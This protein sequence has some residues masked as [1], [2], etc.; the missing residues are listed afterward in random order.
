MIFKPALS[1]LRFHSVSRSHLPCSPI[2]SMHTVRQQPSLR[3]SDKP[4][5]ASKVVRASPLIR[6]SR[7]HFFKLIL[8]MR[9]IYLVL[10]NNV[11]LVRRSS[12]NDLIHDVDPLPN[13]PLD[14]S[15]YSNRSSP[16]PQLTARDRNGVLKAPSRKVMATLA[17]AGGWVDSVVCRTALAVVRLQDSIDTDDWKSGLLEGGHD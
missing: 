15:Y 8:S 5:A 9:T 7:G 10:P 1:P 6:A 14:G 12:P 3:C 16:L 13:E 4:K 11:S 2:T 17:D